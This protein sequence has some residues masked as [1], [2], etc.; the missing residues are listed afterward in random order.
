MRLC[1]KGS[2]DLLEQGGTHIKKQ[3]RLRLAHIRFK[4]KHRSSSLELQEST[5][6]HTLR[7]MTGVHTWFMASTFFVEAL[8]SMDLRGWLE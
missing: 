2:A 4:E 1:A 8:R 6:T 7:S 5:H 3:T